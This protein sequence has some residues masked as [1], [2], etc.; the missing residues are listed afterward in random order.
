MG[1]PASR[2]P[3]VKIAAEIRQDTCERN[4]NQRAFA[5]TMRMLRNRISVFISLLIKSLD[6]LSLR[7]RL[8]EIGKGRDWTDTSHASD[9]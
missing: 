9:R 5:D 6:R 1:I 2:G 8:D 7:R 4:A 3:I